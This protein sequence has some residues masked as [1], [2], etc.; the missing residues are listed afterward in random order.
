MNEKYDWDL[1]LKGLVKRSYLRGAQRGLLEARALTAAK[2]A[3]VFTVG[4]VF[5]I[6]VG[7][8]LTGWLP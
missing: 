3:F 2:V 4:V 1:Q 8:W 7:L 6:I 5:G